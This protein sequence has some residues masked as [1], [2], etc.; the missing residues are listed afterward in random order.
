[1]ALSFNWTSELDSSLMKR[2]LSAAVDFQI[3]LLHL[4]KTRSE[5]AIRRFKG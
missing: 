1:M 2:P 4:D 3:R 5:N